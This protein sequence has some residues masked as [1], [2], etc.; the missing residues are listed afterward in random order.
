MARPAVVSR[1]R[2]RNEKG[3]RTNERSFNLD[4]IKTIAFVI[5]GAILLFGCFDAETT[6]T[7]NILQDGEFSS[8]DLLG[9]PHNSGNHVYP[10]MATL[11]TCC[12]LTGLVVVICIMGAQMD[13]AF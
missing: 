1:D 10:Y 13:T 8:F 12:C 2:I 5:I 11:I 4:L 6:L 3:E 9:L 7:H